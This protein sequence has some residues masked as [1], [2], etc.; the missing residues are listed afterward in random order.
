[1]RFHLSKYM[2]NAKQKIGDVNE[3]CKL[4]NLKN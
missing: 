2:K 1:M 3:K 4:K